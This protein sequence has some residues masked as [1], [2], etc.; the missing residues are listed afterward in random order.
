MKYDLL[1]VGAGLYGAVIAHEATEA[2]KSVL[3][4]DKRNHIGGNCYVDRTNDDI[5]VHMYGAHIFHTDKKYIWDYVNKFVSFDNYCHQVVAKSGQKLYSLP[6]SLRTLYD[7]WGIDSVPTM[8]SYLEEQKTHT[9]NPKNL[10]EQAL[11]LVGYGVYKTLIEGYTEKQWGKKCT[12]LPASI[13]NRL[14]VRMTFDT[15]YFSDRYQGVANYTIMIYNMLMGCDLSLCSDFFKDREFY[16]NIA[17]QIVFTGPIDEFYEYKFGQLEYRSLRFETERLELENYQGNAVV[18]YVDS[19]VPYTR[20]IE[21]KHFTNVKFNHTIITKEY[22]EQW[23]I[24]KDRYYPVETAENI[25]RYQQYKDYQNYQ[26]YKHMNC[27][28]VIFGGRLG[29]YKYFD[30]DDTIEAALNQCV[31]LGFRKSILQ[32]R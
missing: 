18:N 15:R 14:P 4:I 6:F 22:P 16:E 2:G 10:E 17:N 12:E 31:K 13:I 23:S 32:V 20:I 21:H 1:V 29:S 9:E 11:N 30:M 27:Y 7:M 26:E 3:V 28:K 25:E 8:L 5:P 19:K 24:G